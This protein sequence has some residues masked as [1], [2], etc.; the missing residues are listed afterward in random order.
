MMKTFLLLLLVTT[1][2]VTKA[3]F[4]KIPPDVTDSFKV[5]FPDASKVSWKDKVVYFQAEFVT[6]E[7]VQRANFSIE[8][9]WLKTEKI[10]SFEQLPPE[11]KDGFKKSKYADW[12]V[13]EVVE[14]RSVEN[15]HEYRITIRKDEFLKRYLRFST[16]G[17]LLDDSLT[18]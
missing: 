11:V 2:L 14:T 5:H 10:F 6:G 9:D 7:Q 13:K 1:G 12:A 8:G 17:Q 4:R 15:G 16:T 18:F 3:Q